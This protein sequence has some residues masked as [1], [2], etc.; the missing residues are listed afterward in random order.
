MTEQAPGYGIFHQSPTD[1]YTEANVR[2][3][4][5]EVLRP[6]YEQQVVNETAKEI[7]AN[8]ERL[9]LA[10]LREGCEIEVEGGPERGVLD[11]K[12]EAGGPPRKF[13]EVWKDRKGKG[14]EK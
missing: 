3:R 9:K 2:A 13:E 11:G 6:I 8:R 7:V 12:A 14:I 10:P 5:Y 4:W 1:V